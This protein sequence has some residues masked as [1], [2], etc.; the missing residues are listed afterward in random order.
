MK[1]CRK[2]SASKSEHDFYDRDNTCKECRKAAARANRLKR[3][4]CYREFDRQRSNL[5]HRVEARR[6]YSM[7][8]RGAERLAAGKTA[9]A[10][11]NPERITAHT[12]V[13]NAVRDGKLWKAPC[14]MA[15]GCYSTDRL[16]GH[17]THYENPLSVVWLCT[18]CHAR[19]HREFR[20]RRRQERAKGK[21]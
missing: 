20:E 18:P 14:C 5:P 2:C 17:H 8:P 7:T 12:A 1:Q 21:A 4:E 15:P 6:R 16:H 13:R 3:L 11:R 19:L 9:Y 10:R